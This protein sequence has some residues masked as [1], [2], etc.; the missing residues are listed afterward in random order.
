[1]CLYVEHGQQLEVAKRDFTVYKVM[2]QVSDN[3]WQTPFRGFMVRDIVEN[4]TAIEPD[5]EAV[6]RSPFLAVIW[7]L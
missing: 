4:V 1:M 7:M 5:M 6:E 2:K 3:N